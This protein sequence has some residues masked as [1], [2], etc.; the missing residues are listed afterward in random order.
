MNCIYNIF[1]AQ[2]GFIAEWEIDRKTRLYLTGSV[3]NRVCAQL[4]A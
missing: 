3:Q 4:I 1:F 2:L